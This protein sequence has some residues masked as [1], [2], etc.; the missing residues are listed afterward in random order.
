MRSQSIIFPKLNWEEASIL[1]C[2]LPIDFSVQLGFHVIVYFSTLA[3]CYMFLFKIICFWNFKMKFANFSKN[4][5][6]KCINRSLGFSKSNC[7]TYKSITFLQRLYKRGDILKIIPS[8]L[9]NHTL[10]RK[11]WIQ[12]GLSIYNPAIW[13]LALSSKD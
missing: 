5:S 3:L 1:I 4:S 13:I 7:C 6:S 8:I 12:L 9:N 10:H 2:L 11:P